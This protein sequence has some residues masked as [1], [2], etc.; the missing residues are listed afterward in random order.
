MLLAISIEKGVI[1]CEQYDKLDGDFLLLRNSKF[2]LRKS[3]KRYGK[4]F[5]LDNNPI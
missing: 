4:L 2:M 3:G 5:V 1:F